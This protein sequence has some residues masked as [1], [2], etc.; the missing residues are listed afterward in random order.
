MD[1]QQSCL[2]KCSLFLK[3]NEN[4]RIQAQRGDHLVS[5]LQTKS[6]KRAQR[7]LILKIKMKRIDL[8]M[9]RLIKQD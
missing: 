9:L 6:N 1:K 5:S 2:K 8:Q 3:R 7:I 4:Q